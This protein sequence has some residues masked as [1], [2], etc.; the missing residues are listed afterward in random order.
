MN[1]QNP[2]ISGYHPD[3]SICRV[4]SDYYI[5]N[6][7]FEFYPG[8]PIYHSTNLANWEPA[9]YC[10]TKPSQ[11]PLERCNPSGGIFAPTIRYHEYEKDGVT[12]GF[13]FMT[14]TNVSA[15][16]HFIVHAKEVRG[17]WSE[18]VWIDQGGIDPSL[19]FDEDG[20]VYFTST[21]YIDGVSM[22]QMC[23]VNPITGEKKTESR[24]ISY[25]CGGISPEGPHLYKI[26]G[27]YY[28]MM[29]E[30]GTEYGHT[31]TI[32]RGDSPWGPFEECPHNPILTHRSEH[33]DG[34]VCTGHADLMEDENGNWWMVCLGA[35]KMDGPWGQVFLHHLGRETFLAPVAWEDGW[36]VVGDNGRISITMDGPLPR[37]AKDRNLDFADDFAKLTPEQGMTLEGFEDIWPYEYSFL[38]LPHP[39]NYKRTGSALCLHG[40]RETL[41]DIA[42]PA[43][44]G[45]R[46]P[47]FG[48]DASAAVSLPEKQEGAKAGLT[49]YYCNDYHYEIFLT[50]EGGKPY[51]MLAKHV[52][53]IYVI[54]A[55]AELSYRMAEG[56]AENTA[57]C[58]AELRITADHQ[59]Y[60]FWYRTEETKEWNLLGTGLT[61]GLSTE[62]TWI[63]TFTGVFLAM[64]A[65][66][67]DGV[68][69][70]FRLQVKE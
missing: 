36:P 16:G 12:E 41:N 9:G 15:G 19:F 54:S 3:P 60:Y 47:D 11:L 70:K 21:E 50:W 66:Q 25:G 13:F 1:Y 49:A 62:G 24:R 46:Q 42:S 34:I 17:P 65:E 18:P 44:A 2:I 40:T 33:R 10:L 37:E 35:R 52:H 48:I 59:K 31:E 43:W 14:T 8:V 39:E 20:K 68:F 53:D 51:V 22:I 27:T 63:M 6:S 56:I 55:K 32:E 7:T 69:E 30:G 58:R 4:G 38:R 67:G 57:D 23:E 28:L 64:Y 61:A 5:V 26:H 29:A 45:V